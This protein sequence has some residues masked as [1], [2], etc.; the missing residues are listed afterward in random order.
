M[1]VFQSESKRALVK[2]ALSKLDVL[3]KEELAYIIGMELAHELNNGADDE[4][5][6]E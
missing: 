1:F 2:T 5:E 3:S 4:C 6:K